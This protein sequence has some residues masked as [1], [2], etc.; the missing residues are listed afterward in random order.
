MS[1]TSWNVLYE[2]WGARNWNKASLNTLGLDLR[3]IFK[4]AWN[5]EERKAMM[6]LFYHDPNL[7]KSINRSD[8]VELIEEYIAETWDDDLAICLQEVTREQASALASKME[9]VFCFASYTMNGWIGTA[10]LVKMDEKHVFEGRD[11]ARGC[12][13]YFEDRKLAIVNIHFPGFAPN[14]A[15]GFQVTKDTMDSYSDYYKRKFP[16]DTKIL[17]CGDFNVHDESINATFEKHGFHEHRKADAPTTT[18]SESD[19]YE[20]EPVTLDRAFIR[21]GIVQSITCVKE[22]Q[23][24]SDHKPIRIKFT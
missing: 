8:R 10:I 4:N 22:Q 3:F 19:S 11:G 14:D 18:T 9:R 21:N 20:P 12:S 1:V 5:T 15:K 17:I 6:A 7:R 23:N 24:L 16:D 13:C 2:D